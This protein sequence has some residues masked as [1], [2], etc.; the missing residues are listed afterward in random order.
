MRFAL[1]DCGLSDRQRHCLRG[2]VRRLCSEVT[3][4]PLQQCEAIA[5]GLPARRPFA[6][7]RLW[8]D[9]LFPEER[10]AVYCDT[11]VLVR[12]NPAGSLDHLQAGSGI[13]AWVNPQRSLADDPVHA[14]AEG[15]QNVPY[16][17][18]GFL[19]MDLQACRSSGSLKAAR[20][21]SIKH[22]AACRNHDQTALNQVL[23]GDVSALDRGWNW[24]VEFDDASGSGVAACRG[25]ANLHFIG[26]TKP[27]L[28]L[29]GAKEYRLWRNFYARETPFSPLYLLNPILYVF[30][31][32]VQWKH[33]H[34]ARPCPTP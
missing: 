34:R 27:W 28:Y 19:A 13:A 32:Y 18:T 24:A 14:P 20:H 26:R 1:V 33:P 15:D 17:E 3:F 31:V 2:M 11:D 9:E 6:Y 30:T 7:A 25:T 29:S 8:L 21:Y 4:I 16:F 10:Y 12:R 23:R 22:C 5:N